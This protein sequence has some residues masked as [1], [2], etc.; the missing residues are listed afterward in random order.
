MQL[1]VL[2]TFHPTALALNCEL[3][4]TCFIEMKVYSI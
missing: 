1:V 2:Q 3:D 4:N